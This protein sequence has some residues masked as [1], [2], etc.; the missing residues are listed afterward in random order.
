M[1]YIAGFF[2]GA[3][4]SAFVIGLVLVLQAKFSRRRKMSSLAS[5]GAEYSREA[6]KKIFSQER[7]GLPPWLGSPD[8]NNPTFVNAITKLLWPRIDAA[9]TEWAFQ[10]RRLEAMLNAETFWKPKWLAASGI[11][12]QS[13]MLGHKP[14]MVTDIKVYQKGSSSSG[15][16][17]DIAF[18]WNSKMEVKI[19][20]KTLENVSEKSILDR[21][22]SLV[23]KTITVKAVVRNLIARGHIRV[24]L[25][26]LMDSLPIVGGVHVSFLQ[27]PSISY[28]V[29]SFGANPL[30]VPGLESWMGSFISEQV[31]DPFTYPDGYTV[32]VGELLGLEGSGSPQMQ[33]QGILCCT[34]KSATGVPKTDLFGSCDPYVKVSVKQSEKTSTTVKSN[35]LSPVW[36]ETFEFMVYDIDHQ[37]LHLQLFDSEALRQDELLGTASIP[38]GSLEFD[39]GI[40]DILVPLNMLFGRGKR[41]KQ[42]PS[43][44]LSTS[45]EAS[46]IS[47]EQ[48][49]QDLQVIYT[50][51]ISQ[52]PRD[53]KIPHSLSDMVGVWKNFSGGKPC[54]VHLTIEY[55]RFSATEATIVSDACYGSTDEA[56]GL[57]ARARRFLHGGMLYIHLNR[58]IN[59]QKGTQLTKKFKIVVTMYKQ[60]H[61]HAPM[62]TRVSEKSGLLKQQNAT[63]PIFD[64]DIDLLVDGDSARDPNTVLKVEIFVIHVGRKPKSRGYATIDFKNIM[65]SRRMQQRWDLVGESS[66]SRGQIEMCLQWLPTIHGGSR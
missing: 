50:K 48:G 44:T 57:S 55:L 24:T 2:L 38:L 13:V 4:F 66:P 45:T 12:L 28:E 59:L 18:A 61:E 40:A 22:L 49:E 56:T 1:M 7:G 21:L 31:M 16:V 19:A 58:A 5:D 17:A 42:M 64:D 3:L 33:P 39:A 14:P 41:P 53:Q 23:Y 32:D 6:F 15:I 34:I 60:G 65:K 10:D 63:N 46:E 37:S 20:M 26:P 52:K 54:S 43:R 62:Y 51:N 11:V 36:D 27:P 9:G 29:S 47:V 25:S 35:T 30:L 8:F